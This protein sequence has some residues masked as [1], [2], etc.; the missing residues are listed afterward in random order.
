MSMELGPYTNFH[1][2]NLDWFLNE[3][4]KV[5]ADW[6]AMNKSFSN[7]NDAFDD[8]SNYVH[9]YFKN[10]DVQE[11]INNKL[12]SMYISG[13][14]TDVLS[15][16][17]GVLG[18]GEVGYSL[19]GNYT[20]DM[21]P[22]GCCEYGNKIYMLL[23]TNASDT[24]KVFIGDRSTGMYEM[25]DA[26]IGHGNSL[27]FNTTRSSFFC[28]PALHYDSSSY[29]KILE[30]SQNFTLIHE[31]DLS[32]VYAVTFD[33]STNKMY[34]IT[35]DHV[36]YDV[37]NP[38]N[39]S[40][41]R[42]LSDILSHD[43]IQDIACYDNK[44]YI[45]TP[46]GVVKCISLL[47]FAVLFTK[48]CGST[49][50]SNKYKIG[51]LE[52]FEFNTSGELICCAYTYSDAKHVM[53]FVCK[54]LVNS[55]STSIYKEYILSNQTLSINSG[56]FLENE[57]EIHSISDLRCMIK[58]PSRITGNIYVDT[59]IYIRCD[60]ELSIS[61]IKC[62]SLSV[63]SA[64]CSLKG[65]NFTG[66][67]Y[68]DRDSMFK[69]ISCTIND[70]IV[71]TGSDKTHMIYN[72]CTFNNAKIGSENLQN[73]IYYGG[74]YMLPCQVFNK[75]VGATQIKANSY[76]TH[77]VNDD[78]ILPSSNVMITMAGDSTNSKYGGLNAICSSIT[79]G[80]A[81]FK[82]YNNTDVDLMPGLWLT[83][84]NITF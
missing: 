10:L 62:D 47:T 6:K 1:E 67:L 44:L 73:G 15:S 61:N 14:L 75:V 25:L 83:F 31:Y 82:I 74:S 43:F 48:Y 79:K 28:A 33:R 9:D 80:S 78:R 42:D 38:E 72:L 68:L 5:L 34:A 81:T 57:A 8:L 55:D 46:A 70:C 52:G 66:D 7:L 18:S 36:L 77:T 20:S 35:S 23:S 29:G 60:I 40:V 32:N 63:Y 26:N 21:I 17:Y 69:A 58:T 56:S 41:I 84:I 50:V 45:S 76:I 27:C 16:I 71:N 12:D 59:D 4:N 51:E 54:L 2:L 49:D 13:A 24:G 64:S 19:I 22:N 65:C 11:E 39:M 3:F 37:T 53:S 30:F